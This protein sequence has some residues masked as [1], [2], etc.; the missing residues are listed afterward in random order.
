VESDHCV[1]LGKDDEVVDTAADGDSVGF[2]PDRAVRRHTGKV[3]ATFAN[4]A[5]Q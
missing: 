4:P 1:L 5:D 3:S 2:D